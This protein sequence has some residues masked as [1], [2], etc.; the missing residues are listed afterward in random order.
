MDSFR[1]TDEVKAEFRS[2]TR[3]A[4]IIT[5]VLHESKAVRA[6]L[7]DRESIAGSNGSIYDLG[8]FPEP[9]GDRS[10]VQA[11]CSP[12][13]ASA[14]TVATK[15]IAEFGAFDVAMFVGI[16]GSLKDDVPIGSV[17]AGQVVYNAHAAKEQDDA[18]LS[19]HHS[20]P[21]AHPLIQAAYAVIRDDSWIALIKP[22]P[23]HALPAHDK[24]PCPYPPIAVVKPIASTEQVLAGD[25]GPLYAHIRNRLN[26]AAAVETEG[27]GT[28]KAA[29]QENTAAI[30]VR[31]ISDMCVGKAPGKD[32]MFQPIAAS[33]AAAFAFALLSV[34]SKASASSS[35]QSTAIQTEIDADR[36]TYTTKEIRQVLDRSIQSRELVPSAGKVEGQEKRVEFIVNLRGSPDD[37]SEEQRKPI[38]D[39]LRKLT[40]DQELQIVRI[41]EGSTRLVFNT[42]QIDLPRLGLRAI[43]ESANAIRY[44]VL[45]AGTATEII[46][47]D[48]ARKL[49]ARSSAQ[50]LN[51]ERTLPDAGWI[52]RPEQ[53][54]IESRFE[55]E[56]SSTVLLGEAGSGKS[57]LL[58]TIANRLIEEGRCVL[59]IKADLVPQST[60]TESDLASYLGLPEAPS[61]LIEETAT[62]QPVFLIVD[63]L[64]ALASHVDLHGARLNVLLNLIRRVGDMP[65]VHVLL[66]ARIFE[67]NH[68]VR[69][70][71]IDSEA[72]NLSLPPWHEVK[73]KLNQIGAKP[74]A[75]PQ[76][77]REVIRSPQALKTFLALPYRSDDQPFSKYQSMLEQ[78]WTRKIVA[79]E[80]GAALSS[81]A[82][83][84][85][86]I[87]AEEES[88]W[89]AASRFDLDASLLLELES[90]GFLVR[91]QDGKRVGFSHQ[92]VFEFV[93]ARSFVRTAGQLSSYVIERQN[94]LFVRAK[95]WAA[96]HYLRDTELSSY[97]R[98]LLD[99]W[100]YENLRLHLRLLLLEFLGSL[101]EPEPFE[102]DCLDAAFQRAD[103]RPATLASIAGS[104]GWFRHFA[105]SAIA[106]C[107]NGRDEEAS[108]ALRILIRAWSFARDEVVHLLQREWL[109][110]PERDAFSWAV[111]DSNADWTEEVEN[112]A[113]KI[114]SRT[115]ISNGQIDSTASALAVQNPKAALTLVREKL[116]SVFKSAK[117]A[118]AGAPYP[119]GGS[120][121]QLVAWHINDN[122]AKKF[123]E[124]LEN[125]EWHSLPAIAETEPK[126]FLEIL[127]P[128]YVSILIE[129]SHLDHRGEKNAA[130]SGFYSLDVIPDAND[131][132]VRDASPLISG[133]RLAVEGVA[134]DDSEY[135]RTWIAEYASVNSAPIQ[136]IVAHGFSVE[137]ERYAQAA[138]DWLVEDA[139]RL[140]LG[141]FNHPRRTTVVLLRA[142][143]PYLR[144]HQIKELESCIDRYSPP[145]SS[146]SV[147]EDDQRVWDS[148]VRI[149][150]AQLLDALPRDSISE[151]SKRLI[152][153]ERRGLDELRDIDV[154]DS[155]GFVGSPMSAADMLRTPDSEILNI[156]EEIPDSTNW[157]NPKNWMGG[158]NIQLSRAFS[159]FAKT[160]PQRAFQL[161]EQ[162]QPRAQERAAAYALDSLAELH[163][164]DKEIQTALIALSQRGFKSE[165]FQE[166]AARAIEKI[167]NRE[168]EI[169]PATVAILREWLTL[170][171]RG[172][173]PNQP[174]DKTDGD[175]GET[176]GQ[177]SILWGHG[178]ISVLPSGNFPVLSALVSALLVGDTEKR[179]SLFQILGNHLSNES[180]P[181]VW[182]AL[183]L[184]LA[185]AGGSDPAVVSNFI[186]SL[187]ALHP[188]LLETRD[189]IYF[190]AYAQRWD[191]RLVLELIS[192]WKH[193]D[194]GLLRQAYGE[195]VGICSIVRE[196]REWSLMCKDVIAS[197]SAEAKIGLAYA[198][199]NIWKE[200][201]FRKKIQRFNDS[202][203]SGCRSIAN[204]RASRRVS[205]QSRPYTGKQYY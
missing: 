145:R 14:A 110:R 187:F 35:S 37:W 174:A 155:G 126:Q 103:L 159:E 3:R 141:F 96:L 12:G 134:V 162:F 5:T 157:D 79:S 113:K 203:D 36:A 44:E 56:S 59:A 128:W 150:K 57:A 51:W 146:E 154:R 125:H 98:E 130:F 1:T 80:H 54:A 156:F 81:L 9:A 115:R 107:M 10:I 164:H 39:A 69:L 153:S 151:E 195:I 18:V 91:S 85:A 120:H 196:D 50:L 67:F 143:S 144:T 75:W 13:N 48:T 94:S 173:H 170:S 188:S 41:E 121:A 82:S 87:M 171:K 184:R 197:G 8:R 182:Q 78:L 74:E 23:G 205:A 135:F 202:T 66:S 123:S 83:K 167:A 89:L 161:I 148:I 105:N 2:R 27:F 147:N 28:M 70:R 185:N 117:E 118:P 99:L 15:A 72:I 175:E 106:K 172:D 189:A 47:G 178:G 22:A 131:R 16:G 192:N 142:I 49:L 17:V 6:H 109:D 53:S 68:D 168:S 46:E 60:N 90:S 62:V 55:S 30:V 193:S 165:E 137:P 95:L 186:R 24:Y 77:A 177:S 92:T 32:E 42:R 43:R 176:V 11:F 101:P 38:V 93:L 169:L 119:E 25:K 179:D 149:A 138:F 20:L 76:N 181:R 199:A 124:I 86:G 114:V 163:T 136:R 198:S 116:Q 112:I 65:N 104:P 58:A 140:H 31:G 133:L 160:E 158:A 129:L 63:Q 19:R 204:G 64:D 45:G 111:I 200:D 191:D 26:D 102:T 190:L 71:A 52:E 194:R 127:G 122:P 73:E 84:I 29:D 61:V 180:N 201:R 152:D 132:Q 108:R 139:R 33:H 7:L 88:L 21:A 4:L 34:R 40:G 166:S 100:K 97:R 183:L